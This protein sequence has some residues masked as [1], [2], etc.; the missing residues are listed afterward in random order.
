MRLLIVPYWSN[1]IT[2]I[3]KI[4]ICVCA[5]LHMQYTCI[6]QITPPFNDLDND[7]VED[8]V[9]WDSD[10]DG[11][12]DSQESVVCELVDI[13][14]LNGSTDALNAFNDANITVGGVN[15]SLIQIET[16]LTFVGGATI[17]EFIVSDDH[18]GNEVGMLLGVISDDPSEYLGTYYNFSSPVYEFNFKIFDLDRTDAITVNGYFEGVLQSFTIQDQGICVAFNGDTEFISTCNVQAG[19]DP[20]E[21]RDHSF[22][23]TF[24]GF[25]DRLEFTYYDQGPGGGGSFT[26]VP[27]PEPT[28]LGLDHDQDGIPDFLDLDSD[29]DGIPDA[30]EAC[31]DITIALDNCTL[32]FDNSESYTLT[33]GVSSGQLQNICITAPIDTDNDNIPDYLDLDSDGDSCPDSIEECV[34]FSNANQSSQSDGYDSPAAEVNEFGLLAEGD[35]SCFVATTTDWLDPNAICLS[36]SI[37]LISAT[38]CFEENGIAEITIEGGKLPYTISWANGES[39]TS[40]SNLAPGIASVTISDACDQMIINEISIPE[41]SCTIGISITKQADVSQLSCPASVG[42][43]ISYTFIVCNTGTGKLRNIEVDDILFPV[44]NQIDTLLGMACDSLEFSG[45]YQLTQVDIDNGSLFNQATVSATQPSGDSIEA[46]DDTTILLDQ[47]ASIDIMKIANPQDENGN[48]VFEVNETIEYSFLLHNTG[49]VTLRNLIIIDEFVTVTGNPIQTFAPGSMD[50]SQ[51]SA[52]YTITQSDVNQGFVFNQ[53]SV[54]AQDPNDQDVMDEDDSNI[55]LEQSPEIMLLKEGIFTDENQ[56]GLSQA[57]ETIEYIFTV[58]NSGNVTLTNVVITDPIISVSGTIDFLE[59]GAVDAESFIGSYTITQSDIDNGMVSNSALIQ[60]NDP[61]ENTVTDISDDPTNPEDID[62]DGDGDP[63]DSTTTS[64][65]QASDITLLKQGSFIDENGDGLAQV[66]ESIAYT[67]T[68][69]NSGNTTLTNISIADPL[70]T[71]AGNIQTLLPGAQ[72]ESSISANY[73][74]TQADIDIGFVQNSSLLT[75]TDP[76]DQLV[77][78]LSDDPT[79]ETNLDENNDGN[80]DDPTV[81]ALAQLATIEVELSATLIDENAD[82]LGQP[83]ETIEYNLTILNTGNVTLNQ[84]ELDLP[85]VNIQTVEGFSLEP[86]QTNNSGFTINYS[87]IQEDIDLAFVERSASVSATS[88]TGLVAS[89]ISDDPADLTNID[90]N[91]NGTPD[92]PTRV[93]INQLAGIKIHKSGELL[94]N[95]MPAELGQEIAYSFIIENIGNVTLTEVSLT[96]PLVNVQ[97]TPI[98]SLPPGEQD[99]SQFGALYNITQSDINNG[100]VFNEAFVSGID[101]QQELVEDAD[102]VQIDITQRAELLLFKS[103]EWIDQNG[104]EIAQ[105]GER[106]NYEFSIV[107]NGNVTID[108]ISIQDPNITFETNPIISLEP[109]ESDNSS[110]T[111]NYTITQED[112][113]RGIYENS[114]LVT[115][116]DPDDIIVSDIS[117]DPENEDN[118]DVEDDGEGDD[119]TTTNIPQQADITLIKTGAFLDE[120]QDGLAQVGETIAYSFTVLNNGNVSLFDISI[121][122]PLIEVFGV[123]ELLLPQESTTNFTGQYQI[124]QEDIN[125]GFVENSAIVSAKA[126]FSEVSDISDD[127]SNNTNIDLNN[128]AEPD[129]PTIVILPQLA[130]VN[131]LLTGEYNDENADNLGQPGE[132]ISYELTIENTGNVSLSNFTVLIPDLS[133]TQQFDLELNPGEADYLAYIIDYAVNQSDIDHGSVTRSA[134]VNGQSLTGLIAEDISDDP[135]LNVDQDLNNDSNPDDPTTVLIKQ[136]SQ[137]DLSKFGNLLEQNVLP[138][139]GS[140]IAY[141]FVIRNTGNVSLSSIQ[142]DDPLIDVIGNSITTLLP[143]DENDSNFTGQYSIIQSDIDQGFVFNEATV[144][145]LD[146]SSNQVSDDDDHTID[147]SQQ[148]KVSLSKTGIWNDENADG[149]SQVGETI[150]YRFNIQNTGNVT[151]S[152]ITIDDPIVTIQNANISLLPGETDSENYTGIYVITQADID[153]GSISNSAIVTAEDPDGIIV[154]DQSDD[155]NNPTDED[156]DGD[157][158]PDDTTTTQIPQ[159]AAVSLEKQGHFIDESGDGL[160]Q[161]GESISYRFRIENTGNVTLSE[162]HIVDSLLSVLG[163]P[164]S[165]QNGETNTSHFSGTYVLTQQDIDNGFV[166]N[167]AEVIALTPQEKTISDNASNRVNLIQ[168]V[169]IY[170]LLSAEFQDENGDGLGQPHETISYQLDITNTGNV[171]LFNSQLEFEKVE[172]QRTDIET[173]LPGIEN[174]VI[175]QGSYSLLQEDIDAGEVIRQM[176]IRSTSNLGIEA[177]DISDDP[178]ALTDVDINNDGNPDDPTRVMIGQFAQLDFSKAGTFL[179]NNNDGYG[180]PGE[181]ILY[182]FDLTNIGNVSLSNVGVEDENFDQP[183]I[184][185]VSLSPSESLNIVS[186]YSLTQEDIDVGFVTNTAFASGTDPYGN[187][188]IETSDDPMNDDDVDE[189]MDG[190]PDD[191]TMTTIPQKSAMSVDMSG[192]FIDNNEDGYADVGEQIKYKFAV[193]NSGNVTLRNVMLT[194]DAIQLNGEMIDTLAPQEIDSISFQAEYLLTLTDVKNLQY[195]SQVIAEALN[196]RDE[197]LTDLSDDRLNTTNQDLENDSEPDDPTTVEYCGVQI[198]T[199]T[200]DPAECFDKNNHILT[201]RQSSDAIIPFGFQYMYV[202]TEGD[203]FTIEQISF[204]PEISIQKTGSYHVHPFIAQVS[205]AGGDHYLDLSFIQFG[206]SNINQLLEAINSQMV[207]ANLDLMGTA[208]EIY[209]CS[210]SLTKQQTETTVLNDFEVIIT[211]DIVLT[212]SGEFPIGNI[213]LADELSFFPI[214]LPTEFINPQNVELTLTDINAST[215]PTLNPHYD[216]ISDQELLI[217]SDGYLLPDEGFRVSLKTKVDTEKYKNLDGPQINVVEATVD[218]INQFE[219]VFDSVSELSDD[220]LNPMNQ[221]PDNDGDPDDP[222]NISLPV[223]QDLVCN[224]RVNI[225]LNENCL[226]NLRPEIFLQGSAN[227]NNYQYEFFDANNQS[228]GDVISIEAVTIKVTHIEGCTGGGCWSQ[229]N[230]ETNSMPVFDS[231]CSCENQANNLI[232]NCETT[233]ITD[234]LP[235]GIITEDMIRARFAKCAPELISLEINEHRE[236]AICDPNGEVITLEYIAEIRRHDRIESVELLCQTYS[237]QNI[238]FNHDQANLTYQFDFPEDLD[239]NC[240]FDSLQLA[241]LET[242]IYDPSYLS[243]ISRSKH[244]FPYFID[245]NQRYNDTTFNY[246]TVQV[247]DYNNVSLRDTIIQQDLDGDNILEWVKTTIVEK[248]LIDSIVI[249]T[250]IDTEAH[251]LIPIDANG[252]CNIV[253][254]YS[255]AS[256]SACGE[257]QKIARTWSVINWCDANIFSSDIQAIEITDRSQP[258]ILNTEELSALQYVETDPWACSGIYKLPGLTVED[259]CDTDLQIIWNSSAGRIDNDYLLDVYPHDHTIQLT[260]TI[261]DDCNNKMQTVTEILVIDQTPPVALCKT[262][263]QVSLTYSDESVNG[264][265]TVAAADFD[266]GSHD[267]CGKVQIQVIRQDD[268]IEVV[269]DCSG[270]VIGFQPMSCFA[271]SEVIEIAASETDKTCNDAEEFMISTAGSSVSFCCEDVGQNIPVIVIVT[272]ENGHR[273]QCLTYVHVTDKLKAEIICQDQNVSC[274]DGDILADPIIANQ[275]CETESVLKVLLL[276]ELRYDQACQ[277]GSVFQEWYIDND[278]SNSFT[279]GDSYCSRTIRVESAAPFDPYSIRWPVHKTGESVNARNLEC[280]PGGELYQSDVT[281]QLPHPYQCVPEDN[282]DTPLWCKTDCGLVGSSVSTDT[283]RT[284]SACFDIVYSWTVIDWCVYN[285]NQENDDQDDSDT[286]IAIED[287]A[288]GDCVDCHHNEESVSQ[289]YYAYEEVDLDGI[290]HFDQVIS[291]RDENAPIIQVPEDFIVNINCDFGKD[292][293]CCTGVAVIHASAS[294]FCGNTQIGEQLQWKIELVE[295]ANILQ[296]IKDEGVEISFRTLNGF[297][298]DV[299]TIRWTVRDGC[300]NVSVEFTHVRYVDTQAPSPVCIPS[301]NVSIDSTGVVWAADFDLGSFDNCSP[302]EDLLFSMVNADSNPIQPNETEFI[303]QSKLDLNCQNSNLI[304]LDIWV[305]DS[306]H[307]GDFCQTVLFIQSDCE[308]EQSFSATISGHI[309]TIAGEMVSEAMISLNSIDLEERQMT[310]ES[311][312][313]MFSEL[314]MGKAYKTRVQ[315][316]DSYLN[317]LSTKDLILIVNHILGE[318]EFVN[319]Y[320]MIAADA[321]GNEAI[322]AVDI[323]LL[324]QLILGNAD[325]LLSNPAWRFIPQVSAF[326]DAAQPWPFLEEIRYRSLDKDME[327]QNFIAIKIGDVSGD[328]IANESMKAE[329]RSLD[330][331]QLVIENKSLQKGDLLQVPVYCDNCKNARGHQYTLEHTGMVL[332]KFSSGVIHIEQSDY[333]KNNHS[334]T[335]SSA[336]LV[337]DSDQN[338]GELYSFWFRALKDI[339]LQ[340]ALQLTNEITRSESYSGSALIPTDISLSFSQQKSKSLSIFNIHQNIPNPFHESTRVP[341]NIHF[342]GFVDLRVYSLDGKLI[343][344]QR[345]YFDGGDNEFQVSAEDLRHRGIYLYEL[346]FSGFKNFGRMM[347]L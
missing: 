282:I 95:V 249:D 289:L 188:I 285:P 236:G 28:C 136:L 83:N 262:S 345:Q 141:N 195:T 209:N 234:R 102:D 200:S 214:A 264:I 99:D 156:T 247:E 227:F 270:R 221:D 46:Q 43:L 109:N 207:C 272:D 172:L 110:Y 215:L 223:C 76:A 129:D 295:G 127:P 269:H 68:V 309:Q 71:V 4:F 62:V 311:G 316:E 337:P 237:I 31:G 126:P 192:G 314:D 91:S 299:H 19:L 13:N 267:E 15:G 142:I 283:I 216:G 158:D 265:A 159:S 181:T 346:E 167:N 148:A 39:N 104:D 211:F 222:T 80:P 291:I 51:F 276:N 180:Q 255:D 27:T 319:P 310:A 263:L 344:E 251:P 194:Q 37:Q 84:F 199:L 284:E 342:S 178:N 86:Q 182:Q 131:A 161:A 112:I 143:G 232:R 146:P 155:P 108:E 327:D 233:C 45:Q 111:G 157:G 2:P 12:P 296:T 230:V 125:K 303:E 54:I 239:L 107:N 59:P 240:D 258:V 340:N 338:K 177:I 324:K 60:A 3:S 6:S 323:I 117:D 88:Q 268:Y 44:E 335:L 312:E 149:I 132:T 210:I 228:L 166:D 273:N 238:E 78:D 124:T 165:I 297:N 280:D 190:D 304:D 315:K 317:G 191:V 90:A 72:N 18:T 34:P 242:S 87:L 326:F 288:T 244:T 302:Q 231:D 183:I 89:D 196:S 266:E 10:N 20:I 260:A 48:G 1:I 320:Q 82:N 105:V 305:W 292:D 347:L 300:G 150:S 274:I 134:L 277:N 224:N 93:I 213:S 123:A 38:E 241:E 147:I 67:F 53:A 23:L 115:G 189:D 98:E 9:D 206:E 61:D 96:D 294:D 279:D 275:V 120:S 246:T 287:W 336:S 139:L 184:S 101:P 197:T 79:D 322:S 306:D 256:Y 73:T 77:A 278:S 286:L 225:S 50:N 135:L 193:K 151:L 318:Q 176:T 11:I 307:N 69:I 321:D 74:I 75:S 218:V 8:Y 248:T 144:S 332:E 92:D 40:N 47:S 187:V 281:L 52:T 308:E 290:Y 160:A 145:A 42:D 219:E 118:I 198:N 119:T 64:L 212:N 81:V 205:Q 32:D 301:L 298:G 49:N 103:S 202:L 179:D 253:S 138:S 341:F 5:C 201:V 174:T 56:D 162:V 175:I 41:E 293:A 173:I 203:N 208:T 328:A 25:I 168:Q 65:S 186:P 271:Q 164:T 185:N 229:L 70:I 334:L 35:I 217:G 21:L 55:S 16:P 137:I 171:S 116:T 106:I 94:V 133:I 152:D 257:G 204:S 169:S 243:R 113:D 36:S 252:V 245:L 130:K 22:V 128:D 254:S 220:P 17:D 325:V 30:I 329:S 121:T 58:I 261:Q 235:P 33:N 26:F 140:G 14:S 153:A 330:E 57:G 226:A 313:Y 100:F 97:G 63:D 122:D 343:L 24:D 259:N 331:L 66:G 333:F 339:E 7:G 114:A 163:S 154:T 250:I 29:N 170:L 85:N